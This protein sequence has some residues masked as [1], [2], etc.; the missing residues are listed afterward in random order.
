MAFW[1]LLLLVVPIGGIYYLVWDHKRKVAEREAESAAR[2]QAILSATKEL[3]LPGEAQP[4]ASFNSALQVPSTPP[5]Y[6]VRE[7]LLSPPHTLVYLLL[8]TGLPE[9]AVFAHVLLD[10]VL[11]AGAGA[12]AYVRNE[13]MRRLVSHTVDFVVTDK[14][15]RP[16]AVVEL[17]G[18]RQDEGPAAHRLWLA[19]AGLRYIALEAG[20]LPRKEALRALVLGEPAVDNIA[21][22]GAGQG[23][24][25]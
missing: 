25:A 18:E 22:T 5:P 8:R 11:E 19:S 6:L 1:Y 24:R 23:N 12:S 21:A 4:A 14:S 9:Y 7:R 16:V 20:A 3:P 17:M 10:A 15:M 2:L 13:Q